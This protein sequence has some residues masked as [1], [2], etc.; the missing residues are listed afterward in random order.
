MFLKRAKTR[1]LF[2]ANYRLKWFLSNFSLLYFKYFAYCKVLIQYVWHMAPKWYSFN[3]TRGCVTKKEKEKQKQ[4][5][6]KAT[7]I[8]SRDMFC[9]IINLNYLN[10]ECILLDFCIISRSINKSAGFP[11]TYIWVTSSCILSSK[12][13]LLTKVRCIKCSTPQRCYWDIISFIFL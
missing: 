9:P 5:Q 12:W 4:K 6:W 8:Y 1:V 10:T 13:T 2:F 11:F 7:R 3:I